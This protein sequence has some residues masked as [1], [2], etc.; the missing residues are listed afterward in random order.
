LYEFGKKEKKQ[1]KK[2]SL[3]IENGRA[4]VS[5]QTAKYHHLHFYEKEDL[6][7]AT[8]YVVG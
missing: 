2:L 1:F 7:V 8:V 5:P 3:K 4:L 6:L